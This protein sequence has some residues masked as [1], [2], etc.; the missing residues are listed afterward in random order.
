MVPDYQSLGQMV[1]GWRTWRLKVRVETWK[2][3]VFRIWLPWI[4]F[5]K[6]QKKK[7]RPSHLLI[8]AASAEKVDFRCSSGLKPNVAGTYGITVWGF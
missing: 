8:E 2:E 1:A 4:D 3:D 6:N 5:G 7:E